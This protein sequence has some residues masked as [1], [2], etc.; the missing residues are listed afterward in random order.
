MR[1]RTSFHR[2][3]SAV[4]VFAL[5]LPL[6]PAPSSMAQRPHPTSAG[7]GPVSAAL[8]ESAP[9][10]VTNLVAATG[11]APGTVE[12]SWT[13][14]GD[15]ATTGTA[16]DYVVR[17]HTS[18]ITESTWAA[19]A[20]VTGEP[21]PAPAGSV[22]TMTVT[23]LVPGR[24]Y[25]VA[26]KTKDE[27][28][29]TSTISNS[30][31]AAARTSPH[32]VYAPLVASGAASVPTV[33]PET[34]KVLTETTTRHLS[35]ISGDG[36][37]FTFTQATPALNALDT[38]DVM[39]SDATTNAPNGF[40]RRVTSI[41]SSEGQVA[42]ETEQATLEEA[43]ESGEAHV[44]QAL[45]PADIR[46]GGHLQGVSLAASQRRGEFYLEL[47]DLVLCDLDGDPQTTDDQLEV[48]GTIRL[49]PRLD[50]DL[51]VRHWR[52]REL[53]FT[54]S[55]VET[56]ELEPKAE[57]AFIDR[58]KEKEIARYTFTPVT[59]MV[60]LVPVVFVPTLTI[61]VGVDGN[62]HAGFNAKVE[63]QA[64]LRAELRYAGNRWKPVGRLSNAFHHSPPTASVGV[65]FRAYAAS[66]LSLL[67][68]GLSGPYA[69][70][71][72]YL[73]LEAET[74]ALPW[75]TLY[76]GLEAFGGAKVEV[77]GHSLADYESP[78]ILGYRLILAQAE[79]NSPPDMPF[80]PLPTDGWVIQDL[81]LDPSW[82][83]SDPDG[84]TVTYDVYFEAKDE[85]PDVLVS[86]DQAGLSYDPGTLAPSTRYYWRIVAQDVHG[87]IAAGPVWSF[88][89]ATGGSCP[90]D[91]SLEPPEVNGLAVRVDGSASSVC[92]TITRVNWQWGDGRSDDQWFPAW[93]TYAAPGAYPITV[94]AYNN[95]G[96]TEV[97][98]TTAQV[99]TEEAEWTPVSSPT[100]DDL[101]AVAMP[102]HTAGWA[103]GAGGTILRWDGA[104]WGAATSPTTDNL[105]AVAM[106]SETDG[107]AVG[108]GGTI[109]RCSGGTWTEVS[110]PITETL[111][112]VAMTSASDGWAVGNGGTILHWNGSDWTTVSSPVTAQLF[113]VAMVSPTDGWIAGY[114][115]TS[116]HGVA[117]RWNGSAWSTVT[118][119]ATPRLLS[120]AMV[121]ATDGWIVGES[122]V[123]LRW[124]GS[125]WDYV[126]AASQAAPASPNAVWLSSVDVLSA[127]DAWTV[128]GYVGS[129]AIAHW[130]GTGWTPVTSPVTA[131]LKD[132]TMVSGT[133]GWAV[134]HGGTLL[135]Y[136]APSLGLNRPAAE[137]PGNPA[138]SQASPTTHCLSGLEMQERSKSAFQSRN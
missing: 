60:G 49:E 99:G 10:P 35:A 126:T 64:S 9:A 120:A 85:T 51:V 116:S 29:N 132:V 69:E 107:W 66:Q 136:T 101:Y 138:P 128:G 27:V 40:L 89:T 46:G 58:E 55:V 19:A 2:V 75:W 20:D 82:S 7:E 122:G 77:L 59:V 76:G 110:S 36:A 83:G 137:H 127:A 114:D 130:D 41:S 43:I 84:D 62:V 90:I 71:D 98:H 92:S 73:E 129:S 30:P 86:D 4:M 14:P 74:S 3:L 80:A 88:I 50:F 70:W 65:D 91:I 106:V 32:T 81:D 28:P 131:W 42:V 97:A 12:L 134:G 121:S 103:V 47:D 22:Q 104:A 111:W 96:D 119:P 100:T 26:I 79:T 23:D 87:A 37:V 45:T 68:Y 118:I 53:S 21:P 72:A 105:N 125:S 56:A 13:A 15:D 94:T 113:S 39:V 63:Q 95:L 108:A 44:S 8:D 54:T 48:D 115:P 135:R 1:T 11:A 78:K 52:L 18:T 117:L 6:S 93:H 16:A 102:S 33:I 17:Y 67:V 34:T 124:D 24:S 133:Y 25:H 112:S 38:G 5:L 57:V 123:I 109:L 61:G 31:R